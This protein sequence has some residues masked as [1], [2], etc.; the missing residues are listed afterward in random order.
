MTTIV[1][2]GERSEGRNHLPKFVA[3]E[4]AHPALASQASAPAGPV[5]GTP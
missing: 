5:T 3:L 1:Q 2:M 4:G